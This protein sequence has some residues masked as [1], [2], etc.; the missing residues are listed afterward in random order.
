VS[1]DPVPFDG[2]EFVGEV[3]GL[4]GGGAVH[5]RVEAGVRERVE[6]GALFGCGFVPVG[7]QLDHDDDPVPSYDEIREAGPV[8]SGVVVVEDE[9]SEEKAEF[10]DR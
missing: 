7:L 4:P 2:L 6:P 10:D 8:A 5:P 3:A 1:A 9:V